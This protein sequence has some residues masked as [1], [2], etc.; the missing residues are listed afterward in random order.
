MDCFV[1]AGESFVFIPESERAVEP[2]D[3][4]RLNRWVPLNRRHLRF[5]ALDLEAR[6]DGALLA[7]EDYPRKAGCHGENNVEFVV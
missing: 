7:D 4:K 1:V 6:H 2:S 3:G 5:S